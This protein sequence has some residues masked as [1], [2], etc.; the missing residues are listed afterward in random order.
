[1]HTDIAAQAIVQLMHTKTG[2]IFVPLRKQTLV[3]SIFRENTFSGHHHN[4]EAQWVIAQLR[5]PIKIDA[6]VSGHRKSVEEGSHA[7]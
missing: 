2:Q 5:Q 3:Y 4:E 7:G 6:S 1:M